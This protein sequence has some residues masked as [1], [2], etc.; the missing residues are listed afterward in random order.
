MYFGVRDEKPQLSRT[1]TLLEKDGFC[2]FGAQFEK[3]PT[4]FITDCNKPINQR[5]TAEQGGPPSLNSRHVFPI[6]LCLW[7]YC[8]SSNPKS[9]M[10]KI[11]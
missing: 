5:D 4:F 10:L 9:Y 7:W 8:S 6:V 2:G 11:Q 3:N 1:F